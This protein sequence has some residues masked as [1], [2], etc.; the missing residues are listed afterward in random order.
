MYLGVTAML[1]GCA[2]ILGT[3]PA[4]VAPVGFFLVMNTV[5]VAFE[6]RRLS[7]IFGEQYEKYCRK[8]RR[9]L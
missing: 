1:A 3:L 2:W 8:V 9:W 4:F 6:E 7:E 5:F